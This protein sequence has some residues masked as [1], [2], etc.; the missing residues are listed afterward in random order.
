MLFQGHRSVASSLALNIVQAKT[1]IRI[2]IRRCCCCQKSI[3]AF[4]DTSPW[5]GPKFQ[6]VLLHV[7]SRAID[8]LIS[9]GLIM[10]A[11]ESS[12]GEIAILDTNSPFW[13]TRTSSNVPKADTRYPRYPQRSKCILKPYGL[14]PISRSPNNLKHSL[15]I[16]NRM[17][18]RDQ[19]CIG[20]RVNPQSAVSAD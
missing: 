17:D 8:S 6:P 5:L 14:A 15:T 4:G 11:I 20:D 10:M 19:L 2:I 9:P 1:I 7:L 18:H 3:A 16:T 12:S 13:Q